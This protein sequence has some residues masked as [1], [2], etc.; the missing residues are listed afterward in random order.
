V[1]ATVHLT[2]PINFVDDEQ[3]Q[4]V[5]ALF[6]DFLEQAVRHAEQDLKQAISRQGIMDV[7]SMG[8]LRTEVTH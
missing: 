4:Q 7:V 1:N 8:W 3:N 5:V 6:V 2:A